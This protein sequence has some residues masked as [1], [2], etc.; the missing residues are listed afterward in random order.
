MLGIFKKLLDDLILEARPW[1]Q[2]FWKLQ[3]FVVFRGQQLN[4]LIT[5][6]LP[7]NT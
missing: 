2:T 7:H 5:V 3:D 6:A 4:L 1:P